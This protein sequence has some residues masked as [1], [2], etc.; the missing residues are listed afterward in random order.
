ML[1][2]SH[3]MDA[4]MLF[5]GETFL[6]MWSWVCLRLVI[7]NILHNWKMFSLRKCYSK[8]WILRYGQDE[9]IQG[10]LWLWSERDCLHSIP[11]SFVISLGV[12]CVFHMGYESETYIWKWFIYKCYK[13]Q[14]LHIWNTLLCLPKVN[15]SMIW[16]SYTNDSHE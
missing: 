16:L 6:G 11:A 2:S 12:I 14:L 5:T 9:T 10:F 15:I 8:K 3:Y 7:K 4:S 1:V 13:I